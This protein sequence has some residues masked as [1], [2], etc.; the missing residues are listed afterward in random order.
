MRSWQWALQEYAKEMS[1]T[2][3]DMMVNKSQ[4]FLPQWAF[5]YHTYNYENRKIR[6]ELLHHSFMILKLKE[7]SYLNEKNWH[8]KKATFVWLISKS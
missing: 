8:F 2:R 4:R 7:K 1:L 3:H 6:D 5:W